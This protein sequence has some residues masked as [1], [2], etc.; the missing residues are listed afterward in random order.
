[1][2]LA[3]PSTRTTVTFPQEIYDRLQAQAEK[4]RRSISQLIVVL[5]EQALAAQ[6]KENT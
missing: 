1:M 2:N 3:M 6:D 4:E 5:V